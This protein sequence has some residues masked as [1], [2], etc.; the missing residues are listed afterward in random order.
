MEFKIQCPVCKGDARYI[1]ERYNIPNFGEAILSTISCDCG[2]KS[3]DVLIPSEGKKKV[4]YEVV[5]DSPQKLNYRVIRSSHCDISIPELGVD[6]KST[7]FSEG[8]ITNV[9]GLLMR[10]EENVKNNFSNT[11]KLKKFIQKL[12]SARNGEISFTIVLE[13]KTG[14]SAIIPRGGSN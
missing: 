13:D 12:E 9:D 11:D 1:V 6:I 2:Y 10:I 14:N 5:I 4:R 7:G 8:F 3:S